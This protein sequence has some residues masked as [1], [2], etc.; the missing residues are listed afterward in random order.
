MASGVMTEHPPIFLIGAARSG[1]KFLRDVLAAS[2]DVRQVPYDINYVWRYRNENAPSDVLD[3][4]TL[5]QRQRRF[6]Q[7][8]IRRQA[9]ARPGDRIIEKTVS[10]TLRVPFVDAVF[11]EAHYIHL[12][13]DGR[14]VSESAMQ[15]WRKPPSWGALWDKLRRMSPRNMGYVVWFGR[16]LLSGLVSGRG[17]GAVWGPRYPGIDRDVH[18]KTLAEICALQWKTSVESATRDLA[19]L[20]EAQSRVHRIR[21]EDLIA[22]ETCLAKLVDA[23]NLSGKN[24][25]VDRWRTCVR[26]SE[27]RFGALNPAEKSQITTII[28]DRLKIEGYQ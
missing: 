17:G 10:N 14:D 1:T 22:D 25:I 4:A 26:R 13:R 27:S 7:G 11:P 9:R 21:Y 24:A 18:D 6:I 15:Q 5:T 16:N 3:P 2:D 8:E 19:A 20:P 28:G 23:L 12:L